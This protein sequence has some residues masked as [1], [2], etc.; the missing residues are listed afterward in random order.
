MTFLILSK[1]NKTDVC[2]S[3]KSGQEISRPLLSCC[4]IIIFI[5]DRFCPAS[6][7]TGSNIYI[8]GLF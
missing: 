6:V 4:N 2:Y 5:V 3:A 7:R 8:R 1:A